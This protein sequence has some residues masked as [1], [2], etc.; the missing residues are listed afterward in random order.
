MK[1]AIVY[2][3]GF[4]LYFSLKGNEW[5]KY[6]WLNL[7]KLSSALLYPGHF[8]SKVK[9]FTSA[10][11]KP[12]DKVDRQQTY[13]RALRTL[14]FLEIIYGKYQYNE[15]ECFSCRRKIPIPKEKKTDVNIAVNLIMDAVQNNC[16]VQYLMTGDSDLAPA[17][18]AVKA[19]SPKREIY[20]LCPPKPITC[21][22]GDDK[23]KSRVSKELIQLC[24]N[25]IHIKE[26]HLRECVFDD[27]IKN[28]YGSIITRPPRWC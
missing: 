9:Y 11:R 28:T 15:I 12:L 20:L 10:I 24:N 21:I 5:K 6:Y 4:N 8:L 13:L 19:L 1:K 14:P 27:E 3:D 22:Q 18:R 17:V 7:V 23:K 26:S 25:H 16:D 2:I